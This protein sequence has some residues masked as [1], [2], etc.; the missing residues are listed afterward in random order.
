MA[1]YP[2]APKTSTPVVIPRDVKQ[3]PPRTKEY[4]KP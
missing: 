1:Q 3:S 4:V 2:K